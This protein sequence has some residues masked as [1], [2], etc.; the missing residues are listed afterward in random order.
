MTFR[1]PTAALIGA[2]GDVESLLIH[3]EGVDPVS[4]EG[5]ATVS[6]CD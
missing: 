6:K 2:F 4:D 5:L 1:L 3:A